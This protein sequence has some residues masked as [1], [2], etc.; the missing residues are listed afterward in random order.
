MDSVCLS[1]RNYYGLCPNAWTVYVCLS[2]DYWTVNNVSVQ[3]QM[4]LMDKIRFDR[5][6]GQETQ[7]RHS[8]SGMSVLSRLWSVSQ[9]VYVSSSCPPGKKY[10]HT[11]SPFYFKIYFKRLEKD[12][13]SFFVCMSQCN[14]L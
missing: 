6:A 5:F 14:A 8:L 11:K 10:L 1:S 13:L 12:I 9:C 7:S 4:G 3:L 2:I